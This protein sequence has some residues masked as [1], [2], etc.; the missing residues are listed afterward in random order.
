MDFVDTK[1][2]LT[3][4]DGE[5]DA[6]EVPQIYF[7]RVVKA[8]QGLTC[9]GINSDLNKRCD[10]ALYYL[11]VSEEFDASVREWEQRPAAQKTWQNIKIFISA[12][13]AKENKQ[14][15]LM[16]KNFKAYM[17]EEQ[18]KATEELIAALTAKHTQQMETLIKSTTEAMKQMLS[19]IN[20]EKKESGKQSDEEKKKKHEEHRKKYN[21]AP[22]C[23]NCGKKHPTKA[24]DECWELKKNK[25]SCT[26]NWKSTK[27]T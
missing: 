13:Y 2:L 8:I 12:E 17:I 25:D 7:N 22:V 23:K 24:E 6:S 5:W 11:K 26:S 9:A 21:E 19:L 4:R 10:M 18:A 20:N 14:N 16:A 15:K 3:E 27:R 1:T